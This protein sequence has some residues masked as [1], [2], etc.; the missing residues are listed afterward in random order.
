VKGILSSDFL[1]LNLDAGGGE[2]NG[3]KVEA[4]LSDMVVEV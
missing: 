3:W 1:P 2:E 4:S